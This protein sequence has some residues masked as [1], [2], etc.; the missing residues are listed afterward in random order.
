VTQPNVT[1]SSDVDALCFTGFTILPGQRRLLVGGEPVKLGARAYDLLLVL[2]SSRDRVVSKNELFD[3]VWPGVVVEENNLPVHVSQLRKLCGSSA[4]ATVPGRGYQFTATSVGAPDLA[5][6][7]Q[8]PAGESERSPISVGGN[9][10]AVLPPLIGREVEQ[11]EVLQMMRE[12]RWVTVSG[13]GGMGKTRLAEA[14]GLVMAQEMPV[15]IIE[16]ATVN[17]PGQV[18][19]AVAQG[20]GATVVDIEK[21]MDGVVSA[22]SHDE[23]LLIL[24]NCEHLTEAVGELCT[25]LLALLPRLRLLVTSQE[26][27]RRAQETVYKLGPLSLPDRADLASVAAC[28]AVMLLR[29]RVR[30]QWRQFEVTPENVDDAASICRQ[31]DGLPL[32]IELAA[33]RVPQFGLGGVRERLREMFRLLTGDARVRLRRHQTLRAAMDWSYQLLGAQEQRMLRRLGSFSGS[34][35]IQGVREIGCD[36]GEDDWE[37]LDALGSLIDKSLVQVRDHDPPRYLLLETTRAYA[38]EQLA[39]SGETESVL[40]RHAQ[41]TASVC[42]LA[43]RQRDTQAIWDEVANVR[44]AF[45]WAMRHDRSD[46]AV[47]LAIESSAVFALGGLVGEVLERLLA[48]EP[49]VDDR[50]PLAQAAKY[51]Q[52]L[53]RFGNDG[54]LPARRCVAAL[55]TAEQMFRRLGNHRHV[56]ACLRMQA[57]ALLDLGNTDDAYLTIDQARQLEEHGH[58]VADRMRRLRIEGM[59]LDARGQFDSAIERLEQALALARLADVHRYVATLTQDIGQT[60]LNSGDALRA[61]QRF[62]AVL[63]DRR[64]DLSVALA[65]AYARMGLATA[66]LMQGQLVHARAAALEAIPLLRSCGILLA[67]TECLAWLLAVSGHH[68]GAA[69]LLR[70]ADTFRAFSQTARSPVD[71]RAQAATLAVLKNLGHDYASDAAAIAAEVEVA[72]IVLR[73]LDSAPD[74]I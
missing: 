9:L 65:V 45:D 69:D 15:W 61:E 43:T 72:Q 1:P 10:P 35:G 73:A 24:D 48:V 2:A 46:I 7:Q 37:V 27:L 14:V 66:L 70:T 59:I 17:D 51:W 38:M 49:F 8:R 42:L 6:S 52:W 28:G 33:G 39:L 19:G 16:L 44:A 12:Q 29:A 20:L 18:P 22:L 62:R 36:A 3:R 23:T 68:R 60:H 74:S 67:H 25:R 63:S 57:E 41:A 31:L 54:R 32:A 58:P 21:V 47:A 71:L 50:L 26:L 4:I 5:G 56:H 53:G 55:R 30:S 34:F 64:P 40:A 13:A 11:H